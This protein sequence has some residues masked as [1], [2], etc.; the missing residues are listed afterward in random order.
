VAEVRDLLQ[1]A[2]DLPAKIVRVHVKTRQIWGRGALTVAEEQQRA[3]GRVAVPRTERGRPRWTGETW[4]ELD[5]ESWRQLFGIRPARWRE[6]GVGER[7]R[8]E[9]LSGTFASNGSLYWTD[10]VHGLTKQTLERRAVARPVNAVWV[11]D[12]SWAT[13]PASIAVEAV[14]ER[15]GTR[16][17][18]ILVTPLSY[19]ATLHA[20]SPQPLDPG[21]EH[22][23]AIDLATGLAL[24]RTS[25][26]KGETIL[27]REVTELELP[28]TFDDAIFEPPGD[29]EA[30]E[31]EG[32]KQFREL[33][34]LVREAPFPIFVPRLPAGFQFVNGM[35][36]SDASGEARVA[37]MLSKGPGDS[38]AVNEQ[39]VET[40]DQFTPIVWEAIVRQGRTIQVSNTQPEATLR[41]VQFVI[42]GVRIMIPMCPLS[43]DEAAEFA[44]SFQLSAK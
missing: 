10:T 38:F 35:L 29:R 36:S 40:D 33:E 25:Y 9:M 24:K 32:P 11:S 26:Y 21:D 31:K 7:R 4:M 5:A 6:Q 14:E 1:L 44:L 15:L 13:V 22:R 19:D 42:D 16:T 43:L 2:H 37:L 18:T 20:R 8:A 34:D 27:E 3:L 30:R 39:R 23:L 17:A 12:T 28:D 41:S